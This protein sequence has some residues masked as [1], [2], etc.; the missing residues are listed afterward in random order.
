MP[1]L[2]LRCLL[3]TS[4]LTPHLWVNDLKTYKKPIPIF[5][6]LKGALGFGDL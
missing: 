5:S 3:F 1:K 6:A 4:L 2:I